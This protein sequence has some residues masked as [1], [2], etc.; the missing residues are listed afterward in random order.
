MRCFFCMYTVN[1]RP[2]LCENEVV[3]G[4]FP[5]NVTLRF[6]DRIKIS[7]TIRKYFSQNRITVTF[8]DWRVG[9][10]IFDQADTYYSRELFAHEN[11]SD[12]SVERRSHRL[13]LPHLFDWSFIPYRVESREQ[14][15][16]GIKC[17]RLKLTSAEWRIKYRAIV[18]ARVSFRECCVEGVLRNRQYEQWEKVVSLIAFYMLRYM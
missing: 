9:Q 14:L 4:N 2:S 15:T 11:R 16:S 3:G 12:G 6:R 10:W 8:D 5:C 17:L 18:I 1:T 7:R 13:L